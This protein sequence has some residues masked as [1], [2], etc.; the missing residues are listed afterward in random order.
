[1]LASFEKT[2]DHLFD[3]AYFGQKDSVCGKFSL[4]LCNERE[5]YTWWPG[6][7]LMF[8][9]FLLQVCPSASL[10]EFRWILERDCSN[11]STKLTKIPTL[12]EDHF[13]LT[14]QTSIYLWSHSIK[15][16]NS[17]CVFFKVFFICSWVRKVQKCLLLAR[18]HLSFRMTLLMPQS[19]GNI[20]FYKFWSWKKNHE[21]KCRCFK[22]FFSLSCDVGP[23]VPTV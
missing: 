3:A 11:S 1:M 10:W 20:L 4:Y 2:A 19:Y 9:M 21:D 6:K 13:S 14:A 7:L 8:P 17:R 5:L 18:C 16:R 22:P 12:S 23:N 15:E